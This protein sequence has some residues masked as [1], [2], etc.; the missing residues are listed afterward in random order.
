MEERIAELERKVDITLH[1]IENIMA[2]IRGFKGLTDNLQ[3]T[4]A[5]ANKAVAELGKTNF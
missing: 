3:D 4:I 1:F 5:E 2:E